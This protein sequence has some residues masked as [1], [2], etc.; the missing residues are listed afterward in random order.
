MSRILSTEDIV[1][2][3]LAIALYCYSNIPLDLTW[4]F[5]ENGPCV[6]NHR[7]SNSYSVLSSFTH[8]I[9]IGVF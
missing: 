8:G 7:D 5:L 1:I 6:L 2:E 9:D 4:A 3:N